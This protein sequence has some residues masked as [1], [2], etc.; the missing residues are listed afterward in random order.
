MFNKNVFEK[1]TGTPAYQSQL[2]K[3]VST[4]LNWSS[5]KSHDD[6]KKLMLKVNL[7]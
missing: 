1:K 6:R 4:F 7:I 5:E 2:A 3:D